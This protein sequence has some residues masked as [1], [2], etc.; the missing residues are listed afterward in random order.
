M[1]RRSVDSASE[2]TDTKPVPTASVSSSDEGS[3]PVEYT[4]AI[5]V[6]SVDTDEPVESPTKT[7]AQEAI[8][9]VKVS[10]ILCCMTSMG[11]ME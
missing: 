9:K 3:K 8:T 11:T 4:S 5:T 2:S 7:L 1:R 10:V 6:S